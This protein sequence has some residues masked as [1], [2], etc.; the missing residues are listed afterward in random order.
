MTSD[1]TKNENRCNLPIFVPRYTLYFDVCI[2]LCYFLHFLRDMK[3]A[4]ESQRQVKPRNL[5][6]LCSPLEPAENNYSVGLQLQRCCLKHVI[7]TCKWR[8]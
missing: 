4:V 2:P 1:G 7:K 8:N 5:S 3:A 6:L